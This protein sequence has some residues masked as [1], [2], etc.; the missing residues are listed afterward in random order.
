MS[1]EA[2]YTYRRMGGK[3]VTVPRPIWLHLEL[4]P[5]EH[6]AHHLTD[7]P[8]PMTDVCGK[9]INGNDTFHGRPRH[10]SKSDS[11]SNRA[12][13]VVEHGR[14]RTPLTQCRLLWADPYG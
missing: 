2:R 12:E 6:H 4:P 1:A 7:T 11:L 9:E 5:N 13:L 8:L 3:R 14:P 10:N